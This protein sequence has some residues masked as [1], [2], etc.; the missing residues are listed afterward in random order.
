MEHVMQ[1]GAPQQFEG[2]GDGEYVED[3]L[4]GKAHKSFRNVSKTRLTGDVYQDAETLFI[5]HD[6]ER[7]VVWVGPCNRT[8]STC[9]V[10]PCEP[11][12]K[13]PWIPSN[14]PKMHL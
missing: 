9:V 11:P 7:C 4:S 10:R 5:K 2:P 14:P 1:I 3:A 8:R 12:T 13:F 6:A